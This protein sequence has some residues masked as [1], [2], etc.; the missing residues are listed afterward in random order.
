M[1]SRPPGGNKPV[2][3]R[4]FIM[5]TLFL[6]TFLP[7]RGNA[8]E[9]D[10]DSLLIREVEVENPTYM[11]VIGFAGG[12]MH[13]LGD[14]RNSFTTPFS[15]KYG[16]RIN[17]SS[18][19]FDRRRTFLVNFYLLIGEVTG[20]ERSITNLERNLNFKSNITAFGIN[21]EYNFGHLYKDR[22]PFLQPF[23]SA[24]FEP[25]MF[26][27]KGDLY[28]D[29]VP[30]NYWSDG[31]IRDIPE[32][33]VNTARNEVLTRDWVYETD[34]R[35]A[36]LYGLGNYSQFSFAIPVDLGVDF[37]VSQRMKFRLGSSIHLTF[38]DLIDN[39]SSEGEGIVGNR[40]NDHFLFTYLSLHLDLFS[41][42]KTRTEELLFA[43]LDDFDYLLFDDDDGDGV[44][45]GSDDCPETP[46]G[47]EV[48]SLGCPLDYDGDGVPDYLD[49]EDSRPGAIVDAKGVEM[50]DED[51][52]ALL[53]LKE[54][55][56]RSEL[57]LYISPR[58][59]Q[60]RMTLAD[61]PEKFHVLDTDG[62][63][64]LSFDELLI[65]IDDFFD[66]K[67][68]MDTEEVYRVINFFFAQ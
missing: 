61:L 35:D 3:L 48:D 33:A 1:P 36:N 66:Y 24:G 12:T 46:A 19:P 51:L 62:D 17:V 16:L 10:F 14:V 41:E 64:Y 32:S 2:K 22:E 20:N 55:V 27:A 54:A 67:S 68:F 31:T 9:I 15:S 59:A 34:L 5:L 30:Y 4:N 44:L 40:A 53:A 65:S 57:H 21:L 38:T 58:E 52:I 18:P 7:G 37:N 11:P 63:G 60:Q 39:V 42:P 47:V 28:R 25:F 8:Q 13:F 23:L 29:D 50:S 6:A 26:S 49:L 45:N 43:E 56:P